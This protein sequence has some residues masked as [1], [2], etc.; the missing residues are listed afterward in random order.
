MVSKTAHW[1]C[2]SSNSRNPTYGWGPPG[3]LPGADETSERVDVMKICNTSD[4]LDLCLNARH[5]EFNRQADVELLQSIVDINGNHLIECVLPF[6]NMDHATTQH[7]RCEVY[8][9]TFNNNEPLMLMLD[10]DV[11][12]YDNLLDTD[13]Y[14]AIVS[15]ETGS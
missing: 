7:H 4:L 9:K 12:Q 2:C 10:V 8:V 5:K 6:H 11:A 1:L 3:P 15:I 13:D 14:L